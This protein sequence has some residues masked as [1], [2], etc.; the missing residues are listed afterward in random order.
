VPLCTL[1]HLLQ[2]IGADELTSIAA[3]RRPGVA[4]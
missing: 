1:V 2:N 4:S 3:R